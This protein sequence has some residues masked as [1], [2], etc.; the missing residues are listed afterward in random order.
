MPFEYEG[1][2]LYR[3]DLKLTRG[4]A[5]PAFFFS[6]KV[7]KSGMPVDL[8]PGRA[9][10]VN[11][12]SGYPFLAECGET[13]ERPAYEFQGWRLYRLPLDEWSAKETGT[14]EAFVFSR[15]ALKRGIPV[16]ALPAGF[17]AA[18]S[19]GG[20]PVLRQS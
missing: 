15:D 16:P 3:H 8:P 18:L 17:K 4:P 9:F 6:R 19:E 14:K 12:T 5:V 7:P 11:A 20:L 13:P 2:R 1:W 10:V